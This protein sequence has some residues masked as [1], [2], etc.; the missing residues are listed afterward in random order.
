MAFPACEIMVTEKNDEGIG[1]ICI[2]GDNIMLGYYN[3]P[4]AT[5][6]V[7]KNGWFHTGDLGY[8]DEDG[9]VHITG[10]KK[11]VIITKN[12]KNVYPEELEYYLG[13]VP[14]VQES[15]VFGQDLED[16]SDTTIVAAVKLD[17]EEVVERLGKD[18]SKTEAEELLWSEVDK[19]N[20][21][22]PFFKKI[23][24]IIVRKSEF[25]KN[26]AKKIIR[27]VNSNKEES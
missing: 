8:L 14:Y 9:Y 11:N 24:K 13:N 16:G 4:E 2:K 12:G 5:E 10:R 6:E 27:Y 19:I 20:D 22:I 1:E 21:R 26:T 23:K 18:Y 15:F 3:M 25:E 17:E 7:I